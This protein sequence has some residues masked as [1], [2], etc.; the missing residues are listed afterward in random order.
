MS[1][2]EIIA[3]TGRTR[4]EMLAGSSYSGKAGNAV[5]R[6]MAK[7]EHG[8]ELD[9][10]AWAPKRTKKTVV[11]E[12]AAHELGVETAAG[13]EGNAV[14]DLAGDTPKAARSFSDVEKRMGLQ[15]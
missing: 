9:A 3:C 13:Q 5:A 2:N 14:L 7:D 15:P 8:Q 6:Q 1:D 10:S 12:N 11:G 4:E